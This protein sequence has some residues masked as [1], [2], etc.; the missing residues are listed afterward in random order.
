MGLGV[1]KGRGMV[2][3][4]L[5]FVS[6]FACVVLGYGA[7]A[8][9]EP[10]GNI[11]IIT[12]EPRGCGAP[13]VWGNWVVWTAD[14]EDGVTYAYLY[15]AVSGDIRQ[16]GSHLVGWPLIIAD[17][18]VVWLVHTGKLGLDVECYDIAEAK[19]F[20][21]D[22]GPG[23]NL[24]PHTSDGMVVWWCDEGETA[25]IRLYDHA[26]RD[27][28]VVVGGASHDFG[29]WAELDIDGGHVVYR[30]GN[31]EEAE[32]YLYDV[33]TGV[34]HQ[35]TS[36]EYA[37]FNPHVSAD[38]VTWIGY[39]S[40]GAEGEVYAYWLEDG[41]TRRLTDN[42]QRETSLHATP[43]GVVWAQYQPYRGTDVYFWEKGASQPR[44]I[45][46]NPYMEAMPCSN[47]DWLA[48]GM[49]SSSLPMEIILHHLP[50][51]VT[52]RITQDY[53]SDAAPTLGDDLLAWVRRCDGRIGQIAVMQF[54]ALTAPVPDPAPFLDIDASPY[55]ESIEGVF[56]YQVVNGFEDGSFR[57]DA[58]IARAQF[59]KMLAL[60]L[61]LPVVEGMPSPF[62]DIGAND[63][64][65]LYPNDY[66]AAAWANG[67]V[68][69]VTATSFAP[70][71]SLSRAQM[72][73][74]VIRAWW[75]LHPGFDLAT[76]P[77]DFVSTLGNFDPVHAAAMGIAEYNG[78]L[79]GLEGFGPE[80][81]PWQ[82]ATRG[83]MAGV[84]WFLWMK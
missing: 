29:L 21:L 73:T 58:P 78:V 25:T 55:R 59:V 83:E 12:E 54:D 38:L 84:L 64:S 36:N 53:V 65:T 79:A 69:G 48:W 2:L 5:F 52:R 50:S 60:M 71:Q 3:G 35:L 49:G 46:W 39:P 31:E 15:D 74:L 42:S 10:L 28:R 70:W 47:G 17:G 51:G 41:L 33:A 22:S 34:T 16:I 27:Y 82:P 72:V 40:P 23:L 43:E 61:K 11:S 18:L 68:H 62:W 44:R 4:V 56:E 32:I 13:D 81:D 20:K 30:Y 26:T 66:I 76:P 77:D 6:A 19:T 75:K 37:D 9:A 1:L 8:L 24:V 7:P 14:D 63:P 80:W 57:P 67:W 45:S